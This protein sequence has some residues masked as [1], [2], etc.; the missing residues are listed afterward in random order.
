ME[1]Y[2]NDI[3]VDLE[4]SIPFPLTYQISDI[5]NIDQ[6]KGNSSKTIKLPGTRTNCEL[7][8]TVYSLTTT[9][10]DDINV[11]SALENFD[12][13]I[14]A[15]A[16]YYQNGI[17][18]FEGIAQLID[19]TRTDGVW[20][21]NIVMFAEQIDIFT[22]LKNYKLRELGWSEYNHDLT[23]TNISNSWSGSII[24]N[25][26]AYNNYTGVEWNGEGYYYG[27]IDYGFDRPAPNQFE[28]DQ[29]PLQVFVKNI[30]DK[31]FEKI[32]VDYQSSFM[33]SQRFKKLLMAYEGGILPNIDSATATSYSVETDQ[34]NNTSGFLFERNQQFTNQTF[35]STSTTEWRPPSFVVSNLISYNSDDASDVDPSSQIQ[36]HEPLR[37][38][39]ANEGTYTL[40]YSGDHDVNYDVTLTNGSGSTDV[41]ANISAE[42]TIIKNGS[43]YQSEQ[44]WNNQINSST[45]SNS[46]TAS[47]S[48]TF[49][50]A[51]DVNDDLEFKL[52]FNI[53]NASVVDATAT[54]CSVDIDV[55]ATSCQ[56]DL[57]YNVQ[58][59]QPGS[60]LNIGSFLPDM[61]C[62]TFFKGLINMFN[63]TV[64]P[65]ANDAKKIVVE[66]LDD[67][68]NGSDTAEDWT[69]LVAREREF[70]VTPTINFTKKEYLYKFVEDADYWNARYFTDVV[71]QY[72]AKTITSGSQF[73]TGQTKNELPFA[74]KLL[75]QIP[76]T[77]LIVPR[78]FQVKTEENGT[79]EIVERRG[80]AFIVQIKDGNVGTLQSGTW[81]VID[82]F[83]VAQNLTSYPYVGHLDDIDSPSFDLMFEIPSYVFYDIPAGINYTT[84]NLFSLYHERFIKELVDRN[85]KMLTCYINLNA[86]I[87]N[88]LDFANL[89][90]IDNV[91]YRLQK[92]ESYDPKTNEPTKCELI[93]LIE[94]DKIQNYTI[95]SVTDDVYLPPSEK[96]ARVTEANLIRDI[97]DNS[98]SRRIE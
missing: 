51:L 64:K 11:N 12:P 89:V 77:D 16:R 43:V 75:G 56:N 31:M 91:V 82:E 30:V 93:R 54:A 14:K 68:Y 70:K 25:S 8:A 90:R 69:Y 96:K 40:T 83:N 44:I 50:L 38:V 20:S 78:N 24:K 46:F 63:L 94:G 42:F 59:I 45:L 79:S 7:M 86:D 27:L 97:E 67:F 41:F 3:R 92:I 76:T 39:V 15:S 88:R 60:N 29:I 9:Q 47:F 21:F 55:T 34:K 61:D 10:S 32:Q 22:L 48:A 81:S 65:D 74:N 33:D 37:I 72:G 66:P 2:I 1:L 13:S 53:G 62:G 5:R 49:D 98:D 19:C 4:S 18:Q 71:K 58:Q 6:R 36:T 23:Y 28:V 84:A 80:K 17:L 35:G 87:I 95:T 52:L 73:A 26:V 85:G 57:S